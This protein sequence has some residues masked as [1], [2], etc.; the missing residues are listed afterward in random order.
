MTSA[1]LI[2]D[3]ND[4]ELPKF[5]SS[6]KEGTTALRGN[7]VESMSNSR[8]TKSTI[9]VHYTMRIF[10]APLPVVKK[11]VHA[12]SLGAVKAFDNYF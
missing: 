11:S 12:S 8:I 1:I 9:Q 6:V 2:H 4:M 5:N 10:L 7:G 3:H